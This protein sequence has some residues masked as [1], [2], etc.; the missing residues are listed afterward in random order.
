MSCSTTIKLG[1][2]EVKHKFL[3]YVNQTLRKRV[4]QSKHLLHLEL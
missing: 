2:L 3:I 1:L 4:I